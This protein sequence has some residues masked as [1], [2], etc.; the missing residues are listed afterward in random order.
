MQIL[1]LF[2]SK[3]KEKKNT[4]VVLEEVQPSVVQKMTEERETKK[5][6]DVNPHDLSETRKKKSNASKPY[7]D[8]WEKPEYH[9]LG[10]S[11][12]SGSMGISGTSGPFGISGS[13]G[14]NTSSGSTQSSFSRGSTHSSFVSHQE[15]N[16]HGD[17]SL[18]TS[19]RLKRVDPI[20]FKI[21]SQNVENDPDLVLI[22][23]SKLDGFPIYEFRGTDYNLQVLSRKY[24]IEELFD[25][26]KFRK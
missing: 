25:A 9:P 14:F 13:A 17:G 7:D 4:T 1:D 11:G 5:F 6:L 3:K 23:F 21:N 8:A 26:N 10:S 24:E 16:F 22:G 2:K 19:R 20:V 12:R 18:T 15:F